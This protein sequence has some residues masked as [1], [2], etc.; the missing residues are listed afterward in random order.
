MKDS[1]RDGVEVN[2]SDVNARGSCSS[3]EISFVSKRPAFHSLSAIDN[4]DLG[5]ELR[6]AACQAEGMQEDLLV[7]FGLGD[8]LNQ[9]THDSV[10][11]KKQRL[12]CR[13]WQESSYTF[14][15]EPTASLDAQAE[16]TSV[17]SPKSSG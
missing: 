4:V 16:G 17:N 10:L 1:V 13:A 3:K 8:K 11:G 15:D 9:E 7:R 6:D 2:G 14:A 5:F 12:H